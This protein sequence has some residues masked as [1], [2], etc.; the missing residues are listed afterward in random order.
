MLG[1]VDIISNENGSI[2][3][4]PLTQSLMELIERLL[5]DS[6]ML[7]M[8]RF[9]GIISEG[10]IISKV[11]EGK[12]NLFKFISGFEYP[13]WISILISIIAIPITFSIIDK[14]FSKFAK[15]LWNLSFILLSEP[16][17]KLPKAEI[18]RFLIIIWLY[19]SKYRYK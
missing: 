4:Y 7:S 5:S 10:N 2:V 1:V 8:S 3:L 12:R 11:V 14:S 16:I 15:D 9:V 6:N 13:V 19:Y 18:K 17:Q